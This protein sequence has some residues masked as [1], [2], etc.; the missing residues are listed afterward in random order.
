MAQFDNPLREAGK[1]P[2]PATGRMTPA[3]AAAAAEDKEKTLA[4]EQKAAAQSLPHDSGIS[5]EPVR[6]DQNPNDHKFDPDEPI[7][8]TMPESPELLIEKYY[9]AEE[10]AGALENIT[11]TLSTDDKLYFEMVKAAEGNGG[12][13]PHNIGIGNTVNG[14]D[15]ATKRLLAAQQLS[16]AVSTGVDEDNNPV[17]RNILAGSPGLDAKKRAVDGA[18][19][20]IESKHEMVAQA[21]REQATVTGLP[22]IGPELYA[23]GVAHDEP[24]LEPH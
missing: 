1:N 5:S 3:E 4:D 7:M 6:L 23:Q 15:N 8:N 9:V 13:L 17:E 18:V 22:Y 2:N 16:A 20:M 11:G 19:A 12:H 21:A 10:Y 14:F 24:H